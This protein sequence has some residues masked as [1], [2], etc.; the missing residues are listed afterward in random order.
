MLKTWKELIGKRG[1]EATY[2]RQ[3]TLNKW[4]NA[5]QA[6]VNGIQI[7]E[8]WTKVYQSFDHF[9]LAW[10]SISITTI[11]CMHLSRK[12]SEKSRRAFWPFIFQLV[13]TFLWLLF[14]CSQWWGVRTQLSSLR[15]AIRSVFS[16]YSQLHKLKEQNERMK[17][18]M[19]TECSD[20]YQFYTWMDAYYF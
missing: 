12:K 3:N 5:N 6:K 17:C 16:L 11:K 8:L 1:K 13:S 20:T 4:L 15:K 7:C 2:K 14:E 19:C 18:C 9:I 10:I